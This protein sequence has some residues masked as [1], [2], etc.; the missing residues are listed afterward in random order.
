[1]NVE[2]SLL[3]AKILGMWKSWT[4]WF[5]ALIAGLLPM[6]DY[7][8]SNL[9]VLQGVLPQHI[10][11]YAFVATVVGNIVLRFKTIEGLADKVNATPIAPGIPTITVPTNVQPP[12]P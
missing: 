5:N 11:T 7:A 4:I 6:L 9:P 10:Y 8:Q 12:A 1:M 2:I 3:E